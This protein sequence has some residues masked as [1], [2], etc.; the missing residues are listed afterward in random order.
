MPASQLQAQLVKKEQR[1]RLVQM[2]EQVRAWLV[3]T[4]GQDPWVVW[5]RTEQ[6]AWLVQTA[7]QDPWVRMEQRAWLVRMASTV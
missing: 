4:A 3:Q 2:A 7:S 6:R 5:V 1:A